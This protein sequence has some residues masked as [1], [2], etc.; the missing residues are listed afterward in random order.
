MFVNCLSKKRKNK[1][2]DIKH[3]SIF[4]NEYF[5]HGWFQAT[6]DDTAEHR[7]GKKR[8]AAEH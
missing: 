2:L 7:I 4:W 3:L 1:S 5:L 6:N 8:A